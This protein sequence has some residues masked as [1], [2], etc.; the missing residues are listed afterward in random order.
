MNE[1]KEHVGLHIPQI[2]ALIETH[3]SG[4]TIEE[5]C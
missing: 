2:V 4:D 3:V 1:F 5:V